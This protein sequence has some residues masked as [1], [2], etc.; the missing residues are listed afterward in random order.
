MNKLRL[1]INWILL[2]TA[3]VW[4]GFFVLFLFVYNLKANKETLITGEKW[5]LE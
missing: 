4:A 5:F 2:I 3:P 1:I